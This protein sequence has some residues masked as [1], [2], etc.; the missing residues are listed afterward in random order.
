MLAAK[1]PS[2]MTRLVAA[3]AVALVGCG[4]PEAVGPQPQPV[5]AELLSVRPAYISLGAEGSEVV[6][7][8]VKGAVTPMRSTT[9]TL[10]AFDISLPGSIA[11]TS[12]LADGSFTLRMPAA[13]GDLFRIEAEVGTEVS[14]AVDLR[15]PTAR[16]LDSPRACVDLD[17]MSALTFHGAP[18]EVAGASI[19]L[20]TTCGKP[21]AATVRLHVGKAFRLARPSPTEIGADTTIA[22]EHLGTFPADDLLIVET[23][24]EPAILALR[25]RT[26]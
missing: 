24:G 9:G 15:G 11:T 1:V 5:Q 4:S 16:V 18:G 8:G 2:V 13:I 17:Q 19:V 21:V 22:I 3:I 14:F 7:R 26:N 10:R 12:I 23:T 25:A 20:H 6:I